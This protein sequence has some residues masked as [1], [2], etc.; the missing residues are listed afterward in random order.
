MTRNLY[1]WLLVAI[2]TTFCC[3]VSHPSPNNF[4]DIYWDGSSC[5]IPALSFYSTSRICFRKLPKTLQTSRSLLFVVIH[6]FPLVPAFNCFDFFPLFCGKR[7]KTTY[8][9]DQNKVPFILP[10]FA[11]SIRSVRSILHNATDLQQT[12]FFMKTF[13]ILAEI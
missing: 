8:L 7:A 9:T 12:I 13:V 3:Q 4:S 10:T 6:L 1:L 2:P 5:I 11:V